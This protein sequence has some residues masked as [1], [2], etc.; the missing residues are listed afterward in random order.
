MKTEPT[1]EYLDG[2]MPTLS[3]NTLINQL[4]YRIAIHET[5][6]G[7]VEENPAYIPTVG[8]SAFHLWAIEGYENAIHYLKYP[9]GKPEVKIP[10]YAMLHLINPFRR[11]K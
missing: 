5:W 2:K 11:S 3:I 1:K 9:N 7:I 8:D 6:M 4:K 10:W